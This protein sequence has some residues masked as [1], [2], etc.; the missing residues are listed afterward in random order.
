MALVFQPSVFQPNVFQEGVTVHVFQCNV[1][2]LNIFQNTCGAPPIVPELP[3][4][5]G[6]PIYDYRRQIR[7]RAYRYEEAK[8]YFER[9]EAE[10]A[11]QERLISRLRLKE[12]QARKAQEEAQT[13]E[14]A[15]LEAKHVKRYGYDLMQA[16]VY[17]LGLQG[18]MARAQADLQQAEMLY[19]LYEE[20]EDEEAITLLLLT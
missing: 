8:R 15:E 19:R 9:L 5:G 10:R 18:R 6:K 2:Q 1:F 3:R 20:L 17:L 7:R 13:A 12:A 4:A 16:Q 14:R 11:H